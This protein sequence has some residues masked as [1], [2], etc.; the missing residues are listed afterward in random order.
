MVLWLLS[1]VLTHAQSQGILSDKSSGTTTD[2]LELNKQA[3][4]HGVEC[5]LGVAIG[6]YNRHAWRHSHI[7]PHV[8][9]SDTG[10]HHH[11]HMGGCVLDEARR[12]VWLGD[13]N[14]FLQ[15][16]RGNGVEVMRSDRTHEHPFHTLWFRACFY[17]LFFQVVLPAHCLTTCFLLGLCM[18]VTLRCRQTERYDLYV[19]IADIIYMFREMPQL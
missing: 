11:V 15:Q 4:M 2:L 12:G 16:R 6:K 5:F 19:Q 13:Q 14:T 17:L 7:W 9:Y 8:K 10:L 3:N 18:L 1:P